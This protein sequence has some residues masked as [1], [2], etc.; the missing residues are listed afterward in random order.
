MSRIVLVH[1][2]LRHYALS[3][4][5]WGVPICMI[6]AW[7]RTASRQVWFWSLWSAAPGHSAK[8]RIHECATVR[9]FKN[10][11]VV[12]P[13]DLEYEA[14]HELTVNA[15]VMIL[16]TSS[17]MVEFFSLWGSRP[18]ATLTRWIVFE[19][20]SG[21]VGHNCKAFWKFFSKVSTFGWGS[22]KSLIHFL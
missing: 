19:A 7:L 17:S 14:S 5:R 21:W 11:L 12:G 8:L 18:I 2:F 15:T 13:L 16:M 22:L 1:S 20:A 6:V 4:M 10:C 3:S 9:S